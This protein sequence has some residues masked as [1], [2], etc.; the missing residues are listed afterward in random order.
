M[1]STETVPP[2][3]GVSFIVIAYNARPLIRRCIESILVQAELH[4]IILVDNNSTDG[5]ADAVRDLPVRI[6][7]EHEQNRGAARNRGLAEARGAYIAFVDADVELPAQW[8][9]LALSHLQQAD[10]IAAVGGPG[11]SPATSWVSRALDVLQYGNI[12]GQQQT[13]VD[14]L[15][16]MDLLYRGDAIRGRR[17]A[18]L[19]TAEDAELN[20]RLRKDGYRFLWCPDLAVTHHHATSLPQ[21]SHKSYQYGMWFLAPYWRNPERITPSVLLRAAYVPFLLLLAGA[22]LA[23]SPLRLAAA[24]WVG[25]PLATYLAVGTRA[26]LAAQPP[27]L[28]RFVLV[29]GIKQYAQMLGIWA[30]ALNGTWRAFR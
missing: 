17:F 25:L 28:G 22:G 21:L 30:G 16:T 5:T 11:R 9:A 15:P 7:T 19:W 27:E 13:Y 18:H 14:S 4:E 6:V 23:W 29:H 1:I 26:G 3:P 10:D 2:A 20:F 24:A 8:T 12:R